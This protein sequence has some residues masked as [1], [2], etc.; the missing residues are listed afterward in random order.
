MSD[1]VLTPRER[2]V[3]TLASEGFSNRAIAE[4][5]SL[6]VNT[7]ESYLR[8]IY[9]Y[10]KQLREPE[11]AGQSANQVQNPIEVVRAQSPGARRE[12]L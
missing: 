8:K 2:T 1:Q 3:A 4:R 9:L 12:L 11:S 6:S 7:V 10:L 5:L